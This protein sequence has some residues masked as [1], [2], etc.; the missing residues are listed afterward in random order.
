MIV[1]DSQVI[2][3][4]QHHEAAHIAEN[5]PLNGID[6]PK[7]VGR[8]ADLLGTMW[9]TGETQAEVPEDSD[10]AELIRASQ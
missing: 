9:H 1:S 2:Q 10:M 4:M 5:G 3:A 6:L 8:L 7:A